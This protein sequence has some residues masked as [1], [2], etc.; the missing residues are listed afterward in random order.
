MD[1]QH[2]VALLIGYLGQWLKSLKVIPTPATQAILCVLAIGLYALQTPPAQPLTLWLIS[3][4]QWAL[5]VL[6]VASVSAATRIAPKTDS[7]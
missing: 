7:Q 1:W 6:G 4:V 2:A 3:S 5:A